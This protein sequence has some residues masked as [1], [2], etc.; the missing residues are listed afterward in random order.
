MRGQCL[1]S[2]SG[3]SSHTQQGHLLWC[4]FRQRRAAKH[5]SN[6]A[7]VTPRWRNR[8]A[9]WELCV[10]QQQQ[11]KT[12]RGEKVMWK[13]KDSIQSSLKSHPQETERECVCMCVCMCECGGWLEVG[14]GDP[15]DEYPLMVGACVQ[16]RNSGEHRWKCSVN[17]VSHFN[18]VPPSESVWGGLAAVAPRQ[19]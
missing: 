7:F 1:V 17:L 13:L 6:V 2:L 18:D 12:R 5:A 10:A 9:L 15:T 4:V 14:G 3:H 19:F 16:S 11:R 8:G